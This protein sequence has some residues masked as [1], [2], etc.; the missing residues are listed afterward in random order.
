MS[1]L[2]VYYKDQL[3]GILQRQV[4]GIFFFQYESKYLSSSLPAISLTLPK[5]VEIFE[6]DRLFPFFDGL[7]PE[8]WLLNLA[9]KELRLNPLQDRFELLKH[10]CHDT[11]GAVYIREGDK[12]LV[13]MAH[14]Q[15]TGTQERAIKVFGRCLICYQDCDEIYHDHCMKKVFGKKIVPYADIDDGLIEMMAKK[16]L[17]QRLAVAGVQRKISLDLV[18]DQGK[19]IRLTLTNLWGHFIFKPK[20]EAPHLPENEHL[21][22]LLAKAANIEVELAA[23]IPMKN[24]ELGFVAQRFD[25]NFSGEKYHQEDFCQIFNRETYKKYSG[26]YEQIGKVLKNYSDIPGDDIYRLYQLIVF[27]FLIGNVD[28]HL[29]NFTL[30]YESKKGMKKTLSPAYDLLSTDLYIADD[31]EQTALAINGKKNKLE[32]PDFLSLAANLGIS[33]KVHQNIISSFIRII[34]LWHELIERSFLT[35]EKKDE[36]RKLI[37]QKLDFLI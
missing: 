16:Q 22:T 9:S 1:R 36:F 2:H 32:L 24:G 14:Q 23:L 15:E 25:R 26:S 7:I 12:D 37:E 35:Q 13:K 31:N 27:N 8:G 10:L 18:E 5:Q 11:I 28:A 33:Q 30:V 4:N 20:G 3:A 19:N 21:C 29:K 6:S 17:N 34:P